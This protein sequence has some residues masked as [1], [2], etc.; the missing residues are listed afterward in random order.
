M[1]L[2]LLLCLGCYRCGLKR[3]MRFLY[4]VS[5][6]QNLP[7]QILQTITANTALA[8]VKTK[9]TDFRPLTPSLQESTI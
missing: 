5:T 6:L 1:I 3:S 4:R 7:V 8:E 9:Y 2:A